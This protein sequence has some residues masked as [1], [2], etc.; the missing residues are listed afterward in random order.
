MFIEKR[1]VG[2]GMQ[3]PTNDHIPQAAQAGCKS[4]GA[5]FA[6]ALAAQP[7][8]ESRGEPIGFLQG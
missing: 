8:S 2:R 6:I 3:T 5:G 1:C 4:F 7:A